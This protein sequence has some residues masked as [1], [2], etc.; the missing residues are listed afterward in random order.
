MI[1]SFSCIVLYHPNKK[2]YPEAKRSVFFPF[3]IWN[4]LLIFS[5]FH[6]TLLSTLILYH[7]HHWQQK[8][9]GEMSGVFTA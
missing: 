6:L 7:L 1:Q 9:E 8:A 4:G 2:Q 3:P 5:H